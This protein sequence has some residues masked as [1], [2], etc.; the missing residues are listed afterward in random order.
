MRSLEQAHLLPNLLSKG[1]LARYGWLGFSLAMLGI[2]LYVYLPTYYVEQS[3]L[4]FSA[5]GAA[6]LLARTLDVITDPLIG[7]CSDRIQHIV[8]RAV[9][10]ALSSLI[11]AVGVYHL[12]LPDLA[13]LSTTELF[14]WSFITYLAW[15]AMTIPYLALAAE[16]STQAYPKSQLSGVREGF[17]IM[18]VVTVLLLPVLSGLSAQSTDFYRLLFV[19]F[20]VSLFSASV[21]LINLPTLPLKP[22]H[23]ISPWQLLKNI[24]QQQPKVFSIMP[25]YFLNNFANALPATLFLVFVAD[26]LQLE[27]LTGGFLMAYFLSGLIALPIW[28]KLSKKF[29]KRP[30]WQ[31]SMLLAS[32]SFLGVFFLQS[33]DA[34][35][36]FIVSIL[37]GLSLGVDVAM[38][39]SIQS[40]LVQES[41]KSPTKNRPQL[42][43]QSSG[44]LFGLW[45]LLTKLALAL[46][47][48]IAFPILDWSAALDQ[49]NKALLWLYAG[50]PILLKL[51]A[52]RLLIK[53]PI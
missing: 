7:W 20:L 51:M 41:G 24:K 32:V 28:I 19:L 44:L 49:Q 34:L 26:Y 52:W 45:G 39:A 50:L 16:I 33:G 43:S 10:I 25:S 12:W 36:F 53:T 1:L 5:V 30:V 2:P 21:W 31:A 38:P 40:D 3:A 9:Q 4:S 46:A 17:A 42:N 18:G 48:G 8:S 11:L 6:L 22:I 29:G 35:G 13:T 15:T 37:T 14:I 27:S 23:A 47:V